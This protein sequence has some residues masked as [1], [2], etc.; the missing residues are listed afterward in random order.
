MRCEVQMIPAGTRDWLVSWREG[1]PAHLPPQVRTVVKIHLRLRHTPYGNMWAAFDHFSHT[2]VMWMEPGHLPTPTDLDRYAAMT[3]EWIGEGQA[4]P[5]PD[6]AW[7][8]G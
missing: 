2:L 4:S 5:W 8:S 6:D 7:L 3:G 1:R